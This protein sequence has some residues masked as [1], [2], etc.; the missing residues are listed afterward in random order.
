MSAFLFLPLDDSECFFSGVCE[1]IWNKRERKKKFKS[2]AF[3]L[4]KLAGR[5]STYWV[6]RGAPS[7]QIRVLGRG[8]E[9]EV[10]VVGVTERRVGQAKKKTLSTDNM[11]LYLTRLQCW[12]LCNRMCNLLFQLLFC[13][14]KIINCHP[15]PLQKWLCVC[16]LFTSDSLSLEEPRLP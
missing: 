1:S 5:K 16:V 10:E 7:F 4:T 14:L 11:Q 3:Y 13:L 15:C 6:G 12:Y 9:G 8:R 2:P